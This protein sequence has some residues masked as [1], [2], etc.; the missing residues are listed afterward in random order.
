MSP[1]GEEGDSPV[2]RVEALELVVDELGDSIARSRRLVTV[3]RVAAG[4]G[5]L[6]LVALLIGLIV[7]SPARVLAALAL[8]IGGVVLAGSSRSSTEELERRLAR[9]NAERN[10]AI[11]ALGL[12]ENSGARH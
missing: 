2:A 10:M 5:S 12:V 7:F 8:L 4:A 11:D 1:D 9:A 6:L 3:G